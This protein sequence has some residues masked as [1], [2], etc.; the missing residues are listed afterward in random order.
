M[1]F[2]VEFDVAVPEGI[3]ETEV[4]DRER[5]EAVAA[6]KLAE[7]GHLVRL[8]KRPLSNGTTCASRVLGLYSARSEG[9]L[10]DLLRALPLHQW[11][12]VT[13]AALEPHPNDPGAGR[14]TSTL[15]AGS[16]S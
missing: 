13:V 11:M 8:W 12:T 4:K 7:D 2:L 10:N 15:P 16:R 3:P 6:A 9:E 1:E 14:A 5:D